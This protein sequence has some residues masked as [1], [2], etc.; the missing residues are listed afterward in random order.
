M[1]EAYSG[2]KAAPKSLPTTATAEDVEQ[3]GEAIEGLGVWKEVAMRERKTASSPPQQNVP[4]QP[5]D[6]TEQE[7]RKQQ[8]SSINKN[9]CNNNKN[10]DN[11]KNSGNRNNKKSS[12]NK[13]SSNK[14]K[15]TTAEST[16]TEARAGLN[17]GGGGNASI[18]FLHF[19][20]CE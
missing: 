11:N 17:C 19:E 15:T 3:S 12:N 14:K 18:S 10:S 8:K 2:K 13:R 20:M 1:S 4:A 7:K 16:A 5:H 9:C 6:L